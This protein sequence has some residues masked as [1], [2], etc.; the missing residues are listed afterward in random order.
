MSNLK[1]KRAYQKGHEAEQYACNYLRQAGWNILKQ[2][3]KTPYGEIDI[4]AK[5]HDWCIFTEVKARASAEDAL[6]AVS[7]RQQRRI[8]QAAQHFIASSGMDCNMRFDMI[9]VS[10]TNMITHIE[11]A[12]EVS[13]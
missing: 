10:N 1:R 13:L 7:T 11:H 4:I 2:R 12:W 8:A 3:Y 6:Y 5:R 9:A